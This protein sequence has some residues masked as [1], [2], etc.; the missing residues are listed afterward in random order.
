MKSSEAVWQD[1]AEADKG[2]KDWSKEP[3]RSGVISTEQQTRGHKSKVTDWGFPA[4]ILHWEQGEK[5]KETPKPKKNIKGKWGAKY[6][7]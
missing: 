1:K 3:E 6:K 7:R 5:R 2:N 4:E